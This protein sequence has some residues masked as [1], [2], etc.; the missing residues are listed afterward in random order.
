M[1]ASVKPVGQN[2][3]SLTQPTLNPLL[4]KWVQHSLNKILKANLPVSGKMEQRTLQAIKYL[5]KKLGLQPDGRLTIILLNKLRRILAKRSG[6]SK[7]Q[8][9]VRSS[10]TTRGPQQVTV[11]IQVTNSS[12]RNSSPA[13]RI[14]PRIT[15][16]SQPI[17]SQNINA[18]QPISSPGTAACNACGCTHSLC[19]VLPHFEINKDVLNPSHIVRIQL[20]A[21]KIVRAQINGVISTGHTDSSG[22]K[23]NNLKL[24]R[25]RSVAVINELFKQLE[26]LRPGYLHKVFFR[27]NSKGETRPVSSNPADNRRVEICLKKVIVV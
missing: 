5:Q 19:D 18:S 3:N 21:K 20:L 25:R 24:G 15:N 16:P 12:K 11:P 17:T 8:N 9:K 10:T 22:S 4:I 1:P 14:A 13:Q 27:I 2:K 23:P 7:I 6:R 26:L